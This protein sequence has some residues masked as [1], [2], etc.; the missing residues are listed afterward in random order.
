MAWMPTLMLVSSMPMPIPKT[1]STTAQTGVGVTSSKS[2]KRPQATDDMAHPIQSAHRKRPVRV[3]K[4]EMT[5]LPGRRRH[6]TGKMSSPACV[7]D[8]KWTAVK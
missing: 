3:V 7:G 4:M 1:A 2:T 8:T 5:M 6:V